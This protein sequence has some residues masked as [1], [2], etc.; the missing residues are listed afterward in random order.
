MTN[1]LY[2]VTALRGYDNFYVMAGS[3]DD[4]IEKVRRHIADEQR[5]IPE[6]ITMSDGSLNPFYTSESKVPEEEFYRVEKV[7]AT[8][9]P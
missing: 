3:Y 1:N 6:P 4:A 8:F 9:I 7:K 5:E 2:H